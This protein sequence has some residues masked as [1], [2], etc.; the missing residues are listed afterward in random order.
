MPF[1]NRAGAI[2]SGGS[3]GGG[4]STKYGVSSETLYGD[5]VDGTYEFPT[6]VTNWDSSGADWNDVCDRAFEYKFYRGN[7]QSANFSNLTLISG[8]YAF[9]MGFNYNEQLTNI[10]FSNLVSITGIWA[11][12]QAF[13]NCYSLQAVSFDN[14]QSITARRAFASAFAG[15]RKLT[16]V[17]FPKLK[18]ITGDGVFSSCFNNSASLTSLSFP[19]LTSIEGGT[20]TSSSAFY[21]NTTITRMDF[22]KLSSIT[23]DYLFYNCSKLTELHFGAAN[24]EAIEASS[25]YAT[26]WGRGAGNATVYFDL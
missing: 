6:S 2:I 25:G 13:M 18:T 4:T 22:K 26:L 7:L 17:S 21:N 1:I 20:S 15:C 9:Q 8:E 10:A 16:S 12:Y 11:F 14:L 24:Q 19:E 3:G 5:G 23:N